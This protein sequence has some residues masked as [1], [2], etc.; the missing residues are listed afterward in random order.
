MCVCVCLRERHT[1]MLYPAANKATSDNIDSLEKNI[2]N[3]I[4]L[5]V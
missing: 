4:T 5:P 3:R 2:N 1:E